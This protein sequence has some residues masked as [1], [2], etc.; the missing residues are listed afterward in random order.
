MAKLYVSMQ[1]C[2]TQERYHDFD[3]LL[4]LNLWSAKR[5]KPLKQEYLRDRLRNIKDI[6]SDN[7]NILCNHS[8]AA[9]ELFQ[10]DESVMDSGLI[11]DFILDSSGYELFQDFC[12]ADFLCKNTPVVK[13]RFHTKNIPWFIWNTTENDMQ[14]L[15]NRMKQMSKIYIQTLVA[16]W[17]NYIN[18]EKWQ[19]VVRKFWC[20][21][22]EFSDMKNIDPWLYRTLS[23]STL[24]IMKG[25]INYL[26]AV[27]EFNWNPTLPL[28][29][30]LDKF[31][32]S[33]MLFVRV[34]RSDL[35]CGLKE[36]IAKRVETLNRHI[37]K[38]SLGMIQFAAK[39]PEPPC[40]LE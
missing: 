34:L 2:P 4:R 28:E 9:W 8:R 33:N 5:D 24:I 11:V 32:P 26:K 15:L 12:L 17:I 1:D 40:L 6:D 39:A 29:R 10:N 20:L 25:D 13:I 14:H 7:A 19:I 37:S 16:R 35:I 38:G 3:K 36:T 27:G 18:E 30:V 31:N 22:N 23:E 21:P